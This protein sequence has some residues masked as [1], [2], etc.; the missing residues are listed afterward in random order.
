MR[1]ERNR[2]TDMLR[3]TYLHTL[4][5]IFSRTTEDRRLIYRTPTVFLIGAC[6]FGS[7]VPKPA[8]VATPACHMTMDALQQCHFAII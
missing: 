3:G 8:R 1:E 4:L 6:L 7:Q 5:E 2:V